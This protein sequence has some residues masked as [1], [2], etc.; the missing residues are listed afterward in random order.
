MSQLQ[1]PGALLNYEMWPAAQQ[2]P[3]L[4]LINGHTR[5]LNDFRLM[6]KHM[7]DAGLNVLALDNRGAGKTVVSDSF[8]MNDMVA[9]ITALWHENAITS[10]H[11]LGISM[12][13]F[14][15]QR[16]AVEQK[17]H[18]QK[19]ILVSTAPGPQFIR[20]DH[21]PWT[22]DTTQVEAKLR[23]YFTPDFVAR[24]AILVQSMA[25]Q[26]AKNVMEEKFAQRSDMQRQAIAGFD[27]TAKLAQIRCPTLV[28]HGEQDQIISVDAARVLAH[29][30][31]DARLELLAQAGHLLLAEQPRQLYHLVREFL[32]KTDCNGSLAGTQSGD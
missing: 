8:T 10:T 9:D 19:L 24:N 14:L 31:E 13:G 27:M 23:P 32:L 15:A 21:R 26:I 18:V 5:P 25:K 12:G 30:I 1:V 6:A 22:A 16:L 4:T 20:S 7:V 29:A 3:W 17:A 11:V 28:I 2:G